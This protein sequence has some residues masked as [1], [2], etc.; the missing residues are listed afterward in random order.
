M[1]WSPAHSLWRLEIMS[2]EGGGAGVNWGWGARWDWV[3]CQ[4]VRGCVL[5]RLPHLEQVHAPRLSDWAPFASS[6]RIER[7][8]ERI[9]LSMLATHRSTCFYQLRPNV[10]PST[11]RKSCSSWLNRPFSYE[12][13]PVYQNFPFLSKGLCAMLLDRCVCNAPYYGLLLFITNNFYHPWRVSAP[14]PPSSPGALSNSPIYS[15]WQR[16]T[17][18]WNLRSYESS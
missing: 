8:R 16:L 9:Y 12:V 18:Q 4:A 7:G 15:P 11:V 1:S 2:W 6:R 10:Q 3:G 17:H 14:L 5:H 13:E